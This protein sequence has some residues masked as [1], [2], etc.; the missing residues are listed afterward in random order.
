VANA[1]TM[2][3]QNKPDVE[4]NVKDIVPESLALCAS[5][6]KYVITQI[7][8]QLERN[9]A[10]H[11][12][13]S[14]AL[15]ETV[16][17]AATCDFPFLEGVNWD[18][19]REA[20]WRH[21][22][23]VKQ[24]Q[25]QERRPVNSRKTGAKTSPRVVDGPRTAT[26]T[27]DR[28]TS[29]IS[30]ECAAASDVDEVML[31]P[32]PTI[33][34][35]PS[36]AASVGNKKRTPP[37]PA[38]G[39]EEGRAQ[40]GHQSAFKRRKKEVCSFED[41][42]AQC[43]AFRKEN[44][45]LSVPSPSTWLDFAPAD[46]GSC[47]AELTGFAKWSETMREDYHKLFNGGLDSL[48]TYRKESTSNKLEM[49][50]EIGF[51]FEAEKNP[52]EQPNA[53]SYKGPVWE[54]RLE[55]C[56][57]FF[58]TNGH[59]NMIGPWAERMR[60][61]YK[62]RLQG[63]ENK[64]SSPS[65]LPLTS[66]ERE[67]I[68]ALE[69]LGFAFDGKFDVNLARLAAFK[70][71]E[72]HCCVP[73]KKDGPDAKLSNWVAKI[74]REHAALQRGQ[75][76]DYLT[77]HRRQK[78]TAIGFAFQ[79]RP[80]KIPWETYFN[81]WKAYKEEHE[82]CDPPAS[83]GELGKWAHTMR[84]EYSKL[85]NNGELESVSR[86]DGMANKLEM[87]EEIGFMFEVND[88]PSPTSGD[89]APT[90]GEGSGAET[91]AASNSALAEVNDD[92]GSV[93]ALTVAKN[94]S[95]RAVAQPGATSWKG[96]LWE[97]RMKLC[98][99]FHRENGH[100]NMT[101]PWAER[102]RKLYKRR[103]EGTRKT[104]TSSMGQQLTHGE[105]EKLKELES[106][107]FAFDGT[108]DVNLRR[109]EEF[110]A[111][112]G[113][114]RVPIKKTPSPDKTLSNWVALVRR[115]HAALERGETSDYLTV[116]R[117]QKL[118][119]IGFIFRGKI[120]QLPWQE[121]FDKLK[122]YKE[123]HGELPATS[124]PELGGWMRRQRLNFN[125]K[126]DGKEHHRMSDEREEQ[127][128]SV[129]F[130]FRVG[131]RPDAQARATARAGLQRTWDDNL[132]EFVRWKETHG[133]PYVPTVTDGP[134]RHLG[135]WVAGQRMAYKAYL[136]R[137]QAG[138]GR[139]AATKKNKYGVLTADK[140]L[141]LANAGFAFDA[142]HIHKTPKNGGPVSVRA[143]AEA[144]VDF[145]E[146]GESAEINHEKERVLFS[147]WNKPGPLFRPLSECC[148]GTDMTDSAFKNESSAL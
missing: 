77:A 92:V 14:P 38:D 127:L 35:K 116:Q 23:K 61:L 99:Q 94:S 28:A 52:P 68:E 55:Q 44:G 110:K 5:L 13:A 64:S 4:S 29:A 42:L 107:G 128:R 139:D 141:R 41:R 7:G 123:E 24:R 60:D 3:Q 84:I 73:I 143:E 86:K 21:F 111:R 82:G 15:R 50:E 113:H 121:Y 118:A 40:R 39:C 26:N 59:L 25:L 129:G 103:F 132:R 147:Y 93:V 83:H 112:E 56:R 135:R 71:Q 104:S 43:R 136:A 133:H 145:D 54:W 53:N 98:R 134:E 80:K 146:E 66:G 31:L 69:L 45:H 36:V 85:I 95:A 30:V 32:L 8:L 72:G 74:R 131:P 144:V 51:A 19:E 12:A 109:L 102:M 96:P 100:L 67:K 65:D 17:S 27:D 90:R 18:A 58:R 76:S 125:N 34:G 22:G 1:A 101:G 88:G 9:A 63:T 148:A 48:G 130:V 11:G 75:T 70:K 117:M 16:L 78:L 91:P 62:R 138:G 120:K 142:S 114:C 126:M 57:Q 2:V 106:L 33:T 115:E 37:S 20:R 79:G 137:Q 81:Q 6:R 46:G 47:D 97:W 140:A 89:R 49:L 119:S 10:K 108:F 124:H 87:L 105:R 122:T